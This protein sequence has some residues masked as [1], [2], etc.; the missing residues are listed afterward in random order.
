MTKFG[1]NL[2]KAFLMLRQHRFRDF[3]SDFSGVTFTK[4]LDL[5]PLLNDK[6]L[7]ET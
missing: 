3:L 1:N 4:F 7:Q 6:F 2:E 5:D